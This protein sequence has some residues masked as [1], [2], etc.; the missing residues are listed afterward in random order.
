MYKSVTS[1]DVKK[2]YEKYPYPSNKIGNNLIYDLAAIIGIAI[3]IEKMNNAKV[4]DVGCGTGHRLI[5]LALCYPQ[6]KFVGLDMTQESLQIAKELANFHKLNNISFINDRIE[7]FNVKDEYDLIV[8]T[9]VLHHMEDPVKG[10]T[11][12][13]KALK[14]DGIAITWLYHTIGEYYRMIN[15]DLVQIFSKACLSSPY[16]LN[17]NILQKLNIKLAQEQYGNKTSQHEDNDLNQQSL[18]VDAYLH[19]IVKTYRY[20][21]IKNMSSQAHFYK[22]FCLGFNKQGSSKIIDFNNASN[23]KSFLKFKDIYRDEEINNI[24]SKLS[25]DEKIKVLELAWQP[26]GITV[27]IL[28]SQTSMNKLSNFLKAVYNI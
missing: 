26:T 5:G 17:T 19:P 24:Y 7:E 3:D 21:E 2:M 4:L 27:A 13:N 1:E 14:V 6:S 20:I 12:I 28:K 16:Y 10:F 23:E 25:Y 9:G 8:S 18:D 22:T 15:R 11:M